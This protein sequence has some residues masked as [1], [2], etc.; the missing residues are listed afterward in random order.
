MTSLVV[1]TVLSLMSF[2]ALSACASIDRIGTVNQLYT[3]VDDCPGPGCPGN[4]TQTAEPTL[5]GGTGL[6]SGASA[7][8]VTVGFVLA[9]V[10]NTDGETGTTTRE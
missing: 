2:V 5:L 9:L 10:I 7:G 3:P 4:T 6:T 8:L 1:R